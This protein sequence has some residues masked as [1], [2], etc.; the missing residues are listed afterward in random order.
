VKLSVRRRVAIVLACLVG[1][2]LWPVAWGNLLLV[3]IAGCEEPACG[4]SPLLYLGL[5]VIP[6]VA[7]A[8]AMAGIATELPAG[9]GRR[10]GLVAAISMAAGA[11]LV[12]I[13][14]GILIALFANVVFAV[15]I[16][17]AKVYLSGAARALAVATI[18]HLVGFGVLLFPFAWLWSRRATRATRADPDR[19]GIP[20]DGGGDCRADAARQQAQALPPLRAA[21]TPLLRLRHPDARRGSPPAWHQASL[22]P[23]PDPRLPSQALPG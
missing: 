16:V 6:M 19:G 18:G 12:V 8:L 10:L 7:L 11:V 23:V 22:L 3:G 13:S 1:G 21:W 9:D 17:R 14:V 2:G 15:A 20:E 4:E 5:F